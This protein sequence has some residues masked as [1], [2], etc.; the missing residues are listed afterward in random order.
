M[1]TRNNHYFSAALLIIMGFLVVCNLYTLIPLYDQ[2]SMEWNVPTRKV[3]LASSFFSVFYALGLLTFGPLSDR[4]GRKNIISYGFLFSFVVTFL[5]SQSTN[6]SHLYLSRSIQGFA[7]G[8]FA[9]VAFAYCFDHFSQS[10]RTFTISL[11]NAGFLLSGIFGPMISEKVSFY[12]HWDGVYVFFA[13][14]YFLLFLFAHLV[15]RPSKALGS[16]GEQPLR[17]FSTLLADRDLRILYIIVFSLLLSF[18]TFYDS[19]FHF[20]SKEFPDQSF[21]LVRSIGLIGTVSCLFSDVLLRTVGAKRLIFLCS[22]AISLSFFF[23]VVFSESLFM[24]GAL[25]VIYVAAISFFLP[26]TITYIGILGGKHRGSAISLY[27]F[28]LLIGT[29]LSP[30]ISHIFSFASVLAFLGIWFLVNSIFIWNI[31]KDT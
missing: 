3:I 12:Y 10:L 4:F 11:I 20:L 7:L 26:A 5:I 8:C 27:S 17:N 30:I 9:P 22:L 2:I 31:K 16:K 6:I 24:I 18:V 19:L 29:A 23:M 1:K 14:L 15:L 28:T 21:L 25:S 13:F